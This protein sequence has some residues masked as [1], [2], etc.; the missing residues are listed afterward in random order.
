MHMKI[1]LGV[2]IA[3]TILALGALTFGTMGK[4]PVASPAANADLTLQEEPPIE[5]Q[6][7][8][9]Y[10]NIYTHSVKRNFTASM[11]HNLSPNAFIE[12]ADPSMVTVRSADTTWGEFFN[13]LPLALTSTCL[14]T[15]EQEVFCTQDNLRLRFFINGVE[16]PDLLSK[17]IQDGDRALITYGDKADD[18]IAAEI[19]NITQ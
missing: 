10:F 5:T 11:Y 12:A 1:F 16:A 14:T 6:S 7:L 4:Q 18:Q 3:A 13:T 15:G 17:P 8:R 19:A 9:A 2:A